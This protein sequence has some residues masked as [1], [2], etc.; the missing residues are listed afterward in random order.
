[1]VSI[2]HGEKCT[3]INNSV[4]ICSPVGAINIRLTDE[5]WII[6]TLEKTENSYTLLIKNKVGAMTHISTIHMGHKGNRA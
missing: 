6:P 2:A 3:T 5:K 1:M 4:S